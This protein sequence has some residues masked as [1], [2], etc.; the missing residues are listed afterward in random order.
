MFVYSSGMPVSLGAAYA[1]HD[2]FLELKIFL[3]ALMVWFG[4]LIFNY[5]Y[6]VS[7]M[8][9]LFLIWVISMIFWGIHK[10]KKKDFDFFPVSNVDWINFYNSGEISVD[11]V[12]ENG[13]RDTFKDN[14][15]HQVKFNLKPSSSI[16]DCVGYWKKLENVH[17]IS[18]DIKTPNEKIGSGEKRFIYYSRR[19]FLLPHLYDFTKSCGNKAAKLDFVDKVKVD[20]LKFKG[21]DF[22]INSIRDESNPALYSNPPFFKMVGRLT[23]QEEGIK[24]VCGIRI[25]TIKYENLE[26]YA[27]PSKIDEYVDYEFIFEGNHYMFKLNKKFNRH[28]ISDYENKY[29]K[30]FDLK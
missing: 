10:T 13:S 6:E 30:F 28:F 27:Y 1:V 21:Q 11:T 16:R 7:G 20:A 15:F 8:G 12:Y 3:V 22:V 4:L 24:F 5:G 9:M 19:S 23:G 26:I 29:E 17:L 25:V 18:C 2:K 14:S